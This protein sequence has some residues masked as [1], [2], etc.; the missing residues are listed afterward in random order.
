ML[1]APN[2]LL[3]VKFTNVYGNFFGVSGEN[4]YAIF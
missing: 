4:Y 1:N 3:M 2:A